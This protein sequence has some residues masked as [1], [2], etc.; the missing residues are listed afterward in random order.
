MR[1]VAAAALVF[2]VFG[3]SL[4][5]AVE[6]SAVDS[7]HDE[8]YDVAVQTDGKVVAVGVADFGFALARYTRAGRL[9][10]SFGTGGKVLTTS[11]EAHAV[12]LQPDGRIVAVGAPEGG[13]G[14]IIRYRPNGQLDT[15]FGQGGK[16]LFDVVSPE[17]CYAEPANVAV[18]QDGKI[19]VVGQCQE[20]DESDAFMVGRY[21]SAGK[22][23][24][25]FAEGSYVFTQ[26][27]PGSSDIPHAVAI[28]SDGKI[29][30]V[31]SSEGS[32]A[33]PGSHVAL[34]RYNPDG[35]LDTS[36]GSGGHVL[37]GR[38]DGW[39]VAQQTDG[40]IVAVG[41]GV[42]RLNPNGSPD[43]GFGKGGTVA[44]VRGTDVA[45]QSDGRIVVGSGYHGATGLNP[46]GTIDKA[47]GNAGTAKVELRAKYGA[48]YSLAVQGDGKIV[49]AG[50]V[51]QAHGYGDFALVRYTAAGKIDRGFGRAGAAF[52][53]FGTT[54]HS[55]SATRTGHGVL[56]RW[57]TDYETDTR[58]FVVLR[59]QKGRRVQVSQAPVAAKG[60]F[61]RGASYSFVDKRAPKTTRRYWLEEFRRSGV[62]VIH[63][64][65]LVKR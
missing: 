42:F 48:S 34:V 2:A 5:A 18:Q 20:G 55:F 27:A 24:P 59:E 23:D 58:D 45:L 6:S 29:V 46:D 54:V 63:A 36:F 51:A 56:L 13:V 21:T 41:D 62:R 25:A 39:A 14:S 8:A 31:G 43:T 57:Q 49:V 60:S 7:S 10:R 35:R 44:N 4:G 9:D 64:S 53:D 3:S 65:T 38:G 30:V 40:K 32:G 19:V 50:Y 16:A 26:F 22:L 33:G 47:F 61:T 17:R 37:A 15:M 11:G 1:L 12:A 28:Q 52:A